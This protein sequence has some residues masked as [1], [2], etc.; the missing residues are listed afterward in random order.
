MWA[1]QFARLAGVGRIVGTCHADDMEL[2]RKLGADEVYDWAK[3][4]SLKYWKKGLFTTVLDLMGG[5]T[6]TRAWTLV[7]AYGKLF[8]LA[9]DAREVK[10]NVVDP[11]VRLVGRFTLGNAPECLTLIRTLTDHGLVKAVCP[12]EDVFELADWGKAFQRLSNNSRGQVVLKLDSTPPSQLI[13]K[14]NMFGDASLCLAEWTP[15]NIERAR[16]EDSDEWF[17]LLKWLRTAGS[18]D[19]ALAR[20]TSH[21]LMPPPTV[22]HLRVHTERRRL[23]PRGGRRQSVAAPP[24]RESTP[25]PWQGKYPASPAE[26]PIPPPSVVDTGGNELEQVQQLQT[27]ASLEIRE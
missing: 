18:N 19:P 20:R 12:T 2:V 15:E 8:S 7:A 27:L 5:A 16:V 14:L 9:A 24:R 13:E 11:R 6:L 26:S 10:P 23:R 22:F 21:E 1:V 4:G 17:K 25:D 3:E